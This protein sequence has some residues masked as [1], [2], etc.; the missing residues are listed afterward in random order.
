[1]IEASEQWK[2]THNRFLL[3]ETFVEIDCAISEVGVQEEAS[4]SGSN[5]EIFSDVESILGLSDTNTVAK[6]ATLEHNLW[7]LD[8]SH[9]I[10]NDEGPHKNI[11]YVSSIDQSGSVTLT[12]QK[13]HTVAIPGV[14]IIWS[15]EYGEYPH[16]FT[17]TAYNGNVVAA[18]TTV[19]DN[20]AQRCLVD[21][22][23][24][25]YD[26]VTVTVHNWCLPNRRVRIEYLFLGH[27][28]T[29]TKD[30]IITFTHIQTGD[31]L[32]GELPKYAIE[33]SLDN[34]NERWNPN[35]PTGLEKYL[36]E[37]QKLTVRYGMD[38]DGTTEWIKGGV[39]Y[40]SEW[41]APSNGFEARFVARDLFEFLL[42][43]NMD[44]AVYDS[45][46]S[47]ITYN[48]TAYTL[49][50]D[51]VVSVDLSLD[52]YYASYNGDGTAAEIVQKAANAGGCIIRYGRDGVMHVEQLEKLLLDYT[53]PLSLAYSHP[54]IN[55]SKPL[56]MVSIDYGEEV[57]FELTVFESG[58]TQTVFNDF[59]TTQEQAALVAEWV[60]DVLQS[61]KTISG[62]FRADPRL[63]LY[64][65]VSVESKF[66]LL[67]PVVITE[68]TYTYTGAFSATYS[69]RVIS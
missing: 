40:L 68:I 51:A 8:G 28:L 49:P 19:T 61:R 64:D 69:G 14:T 54:E 24:V 27:M 37:R 16:V 41:S 13:E 65:V 1:M 45:L 12:L 3:P 11:G 17:V 62:E 35:N 56:K 6:Y 18:E 29:F 32:T 55:L 2:N 36:S 42:G 15:S 59:I 31:L 30:D 57:P 53:I 48:A 38:I 44:G 22:E 43:V 66:G 4:A 33:F 23:I 58:E 10:L 34:T 46:Y 7:A 9:S 25:N 67:S 20:T 21:L 47:L 52:S 39:F 5:E 63:D 26:R 50:A 60:R